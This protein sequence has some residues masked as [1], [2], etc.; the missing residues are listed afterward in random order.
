MGKFN[1]YKLPLST[2]PL[3]THYYD[4]DLGNQFFKDIDGTEVQKGNVNVALTVKNTGEIFELNFDISGV[5][6][7]PCD[8]CLDDMDYDVDTHE[9]LYVKFGKEYSEENDDVVIIPEEEGEINLAWFLYEFIALTIPLKHV[10]APG[11]CNKTMSF[12]LRKHTA[13]R[14]DDDEEDDDSEPGFEDE[15]EELDEVDNETDPRWDELKKIIDN[16]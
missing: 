10:H 15:A 4:Y 14:M 11:K 2:L 7:I 3:G 1:L 13:R 6:Q 16:N 12:K 5:I 8:R 9:H